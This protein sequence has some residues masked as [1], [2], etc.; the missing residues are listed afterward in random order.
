[1]NWMAGSCKLLA[2]SSSLENQ[3][4]ANSL[5]LS[6]NAPGHRG[7][8]SIARYSAKDRFG[9]ALHRLLIYDPVPMVDGIES[10]SDPITEVRSDLYLMSGL[11]RD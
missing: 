11:R 2:I 6:A 3:L 9:N 10:A 8:P 5:Q 4:T 7:H 1:M